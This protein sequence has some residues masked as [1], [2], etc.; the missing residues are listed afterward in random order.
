MLNQESK[1]VVVGL[2]G[3]VDS[4]VTALLLVEQGFQVE[5]VFM[6]NWEEDDKDGYCAAAQDLEDAQQV[7]DRLGIV[8]RT[9]NFAH[10]YWNRVFEHFLAEY[11]MGRTPNPDVMC[12]KEIKFKAFLDFAHNLGA[13]LIATGHYALIEKMGSTFYLRAGDDRHKDQSYFLYT[14][15][16]YELAH[17][18]FPLGEFTKPQVRRIAY[19]TGFA[20]HAKKDS[21][22]ICFIGER[23]FREF[24]AYY[25]PAQNG[26]IVTIE[27]ETIGEHQ[28]LMYYTMGQRQ[29]LG[30]GGRRDSSE[31]PWY[32]VGKDLPTNRLIVAQGHDNPALH[33][34]GL[35]ADQLHWVAGKTPSLPLRCTAKTRY[36]QHPQ[37]CILEAEGETKILAKF[38]Q[39]QRAITPG[40]SVVFYQDDICLGGGIIKEAL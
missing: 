17:A 10:E 23:R 9:V 1:R 3:G 16:Q 28:G 40:Q 35:L 13:N 31:L 6:K 18:V 12:N 21:T 39:S 37:G 19:E 20:N 32:V 38:V 14:L 7:C 4:A 5:G 8:L 24:L 11:R 29:G 15:G 36:R 30:I 25:L 22:G 26:K 34:S 2:S 27:G 33:H